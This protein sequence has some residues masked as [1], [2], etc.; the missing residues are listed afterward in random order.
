MSVDLQRI[1][2]EGSVV[3]AAGQGARIVVRVRPGTLSQDENKPMTQFSYYRT[4]EYTKENFRR[5]YFNTVVALMLGATVSMF[6]I[7]PHSSPN[8]FFYL[9]AYWV[10]IFLPSVLLDG[11]ALLAVLQTIRRQRIWWGT[12]GYLLLSC[13][14]TIFALLM[15]FFVSFV[16]F[17]FS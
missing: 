11:L 4:L 16:L 1:S 8:N 15:F 7:L 3:R 10:P 13:M 14:A 17:G 9:L 2:D 6:L 5:V 12:L